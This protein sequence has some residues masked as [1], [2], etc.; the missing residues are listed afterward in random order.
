MS[1]ALPAAAR[2]RGPRSDAAACCIRLGA[3]ARPGPPA[4]CSPPPPIC[5]TWRLGRSDRRDAAPAACDERAYA[6]PA[7]AARR[8][9]ARRPPRADRR[10]SWCR[11][12]IPVQ[13][14]AAGGRLQPRRIRLPDG[15]AAIRR[16]HLRLSAGAHRRAQSRA[17][18][19]GNMSGR[20]GSTAHA[21]DAGSRSRRSAAT[22]AAARRLRHP[23]GAADLGAPTSPRPATSRSSPSTGRAGPSTAM[24]LTAADNLS[25][26]RISGVGFAIYYGNCLGRGTLPHRAAARCR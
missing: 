23:R 15:R 12:P 3:T 10:R 1:A 18:R 20:C 5:P 13:P 16:E 26:L 17:L 9:S 8:A 24:P 21:R 14:A 7:S 25:Q 4:A 2:R 19:C 22:I 6:C 11:G